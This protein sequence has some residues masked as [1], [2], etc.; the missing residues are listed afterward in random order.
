MYEDNAMLVAATKCAVCL[1]NPTL[2]V[3]WYPLTYF[4]LLY[5]TQRY[6]KLMA[7]NKLQ[8]RSQAHHK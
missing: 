2:F 4:S 6:Q 1:S 3:L 5:Q 7:V 8:A